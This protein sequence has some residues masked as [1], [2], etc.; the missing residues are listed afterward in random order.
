MTSARP[1]VKPALVVFDC[2]GVL[3]D[4][5]IIA[6]RVDA[7]ELNRVG[8]PITVEEVAERFCG[9][10]AKEMYA[11]LQEEHGRPLP[12]G[13][14]DR[15]QR[16]IHEAFETELKAIDGVH[17]TLQRIDG[18]IC[19][20]SSSGPE[21]LERSLTIT[22]LRDRFMPHIFSAHF[23]ER[24]KPAPDI[25]LYAAAQMGGVDPADC[26]VI[27][28]SISGVRAGVAAGMRVLG[29]TGGGH[30]ASGHG[31]R[32]RAEGAALVFDDMAALPEILRTA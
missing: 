14:Q 6:C 10:V 11:I 19:V 16:L 25:F 7:Q 30:C 17:E 15:V 22:A 18:P 9:V 24:G 20:A 8:F 28:D 32:L 12:D 4:S 23:V 2:D 1:T 29:F 27:E 3:V 26:V 21:W 31:D 5:E 13:F